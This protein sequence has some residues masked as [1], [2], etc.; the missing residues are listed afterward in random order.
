MVHQFLSVLGSVP[1]VI[2]FITNGN[3][4]TISPFSIRSVSSFSGPFSIVASSLD[5][6]SYIEIPNSLKYNFK[7]TSFVCY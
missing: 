4:K 5:I 2:K 1:K 6:D 3:M 7:I